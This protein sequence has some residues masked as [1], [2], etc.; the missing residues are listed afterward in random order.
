MTPTVLVHGGGLD[1]RCWDRILP[2]LHG[3]CW[4]STSLAAGYTQRPSTLCL[5][6]RVHP[7]CAPILMP[8]A[9]MMS[10]W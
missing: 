4:R 3:P 9:S 5:W 2:Y 10:C 8:P 7:R 1:H 6:L